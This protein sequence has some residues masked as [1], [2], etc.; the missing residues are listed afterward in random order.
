MKQRENKSKC[1]ISKVEVTA[2]TLTGRGGMALF[3]RYIDKVGIC[4]LLLSSFGYIRKSKKGASVWNIFKQALCFFYD[5]TSRHLTYF[6]QLK[7][8]AGYAAIIENSK[9]DMVSSHQVKR[10]FKAFI[11]LCGG[12]FRKI[13]KQMFIWRLRIDKPEKIEL[14]IDT[15]VMDNDEAEKRHGVEPTYKG[16][17]G[18][19]PLQIIWKNKIVDAIFRGG[20]KHGNYGKTVVNMVTEL[21]KLIRKEYSATVPIILKFDSG[22]FDE[23]NFEAFDRLGIGFIATGKM[24]TSVKEYIGGQEGIKWDKYDN[25]HQ[26]W[27]YKEFGY[28]CETWKRFYRAIY[29]RPYYEGE[30]RLLD[31][32]RPDNIILTNIGINDKVLAGCSEALRKGMIKAEA[33]ISSHH[34]RGADELPHRGIKDFGFEELPFKRFPANSAFYYCM[35]ITFFLFETFKEDVLEEIMPIGSYATTV[36]RKALD[37]AA[38]I[39][40]NS[41]QIILK[42]TQAVMDALRFD[43]LWER[44]NDP[45][46]IVT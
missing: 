7:E 29:T 10:F 35:V 11:W 22:F 24:Y 25:R 15:M 18:F 43:R 31:F 37:F 39:V 5:G 38:K 26:E 32:A 16:V 46:P 3:V 9:E 13:L 19:Q 8:D 36:R 14:T 44:C 33:I 17:K 21:V 1:K 4:N 40:R 45:V 34:Q 6:D 23:E 2:D 30:Q 41:R 12:I 27:E 28:R 42:V 20:K